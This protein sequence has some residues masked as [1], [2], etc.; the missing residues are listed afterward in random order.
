MKLTRRDFL[1]L[2]GLLPA[3]P[4]VGKLDK[5]IPQPEPEQVETP[6]KFTVPPEGEGY[7]MVSARAYI[8]GYAK[9]TVMELRRNGQPI[10]TSACDFSRPY[11]GS[12]LSLSQVV[13]KDSKDVLDVRLYGRSGDWQI[14][15]D[16]TPIDF[17]TFRIM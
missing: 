4:V 2:F 6:Y 13:Y 11:T 1:K 9:E 7:Y 15:M 14:P 16:E 10:G 5:L 12:L 17:K 3:V 8:P